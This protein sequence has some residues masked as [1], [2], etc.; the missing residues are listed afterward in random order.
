MIEDIF[1]KPRTRILQLLVSRPEW[2]FSE[3]EIAAELELP[4]ATVH[5]NL[6]VLVEAGILR[7]FKKG[8]ATVYTLNKTNYVVKEL[9]IPFLQAERE[10]PIKKARE[11]CT[12]TKI[13]SQI[14]LGAVFGSAAMGKMS[15]TSDIDIALVTTREQLDKLKEDVRL[16]KA[17]SLEKENIIFSVHIF[18][19]EEFVHRYEKKDP[20]MIAITNGKVVQGNLDVL[21]K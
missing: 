19:K 12:S 1:T 21:L 7:G 11:F 6:P 14:L 15:P 2:I 4:K 16:L 5:T 3:S 20:F 13:V 10:L 8:R 17:E 9:L 18:T